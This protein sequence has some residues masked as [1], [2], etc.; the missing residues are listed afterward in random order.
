M[1]KDQKITISIIESESVMRESRAI[2]QLVF[3]EE[4]NVAPEIEYDEFEGV[5]THIIARMGTKAV[6]TARWRQTDKGFK[7]ERFAVLLSARGLGVGDALVR[8]VLDHIE[9]R[10]KAYLNSQTSA[11]GFYAKLGFREVGEIFYE[12]DIPHRKMIYRP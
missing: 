4:Q 2:R 5:A 9:D 8:F 3:V 12:A 1:T 11:I 10:S 6:G 7:L